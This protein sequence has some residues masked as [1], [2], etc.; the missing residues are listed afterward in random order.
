V[1][2]QLQPATIAGEGCQE[3]ALL[4]AL[5]IHQ[6]PVQESPEWRVNSGLSTVRG[7]S[8]RARSASPG[9]LRDAAGATQLRSLEA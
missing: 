9:V 6:G 1:P 5:R 7:L 3:Q 2:K 4:T 8:S